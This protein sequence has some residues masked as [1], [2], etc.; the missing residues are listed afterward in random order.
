M[1]TILVIWPIYITLNNYMIVNNELE[2]TWREIIETK[3]KLIS[4][5]LPGETEK[6]NKSCPESWVRTEPLLNMSERYRLS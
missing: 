1:T 4:R 3:F 2:G 5:H 6:S